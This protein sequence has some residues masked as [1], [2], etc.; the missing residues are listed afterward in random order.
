[1]MDRFILLTILQVVALTFAFELRCPVSGEW[2]LRA[3]TFNCSSSQYVCL[4]HIRYRLE[5]IYKESCDELDY[6]SIGSKL[7]FQPIFNQAQCTYKRYQPF[8]F[9]TDGSSNCVYHKS[10]CNEEGQYVFN[11]G[12][13]NND[14]TCGCNSSKG[15]KFIIKPRNNCFCIPSEEDCSCHKVTC[16]ERDHPCRQ[17]GSVFMNASCLEI[18]TK[19]LPESNKSA[20]SVRGRINVTQYKTEYANKGIS[21]QQYCAYATVTLLIIMIS[22]VPIYGE[23]QVK[24]KSKNNRNDIF[25]VKREA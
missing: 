25:I 12:S 10:F 24:M 5:D 9:S 17:D 20:P 3:K 11:K 18:T 8:L 16:N 21:Y 7:V 13:F 19:G 22:T 4:L 15:Y 2:R 1:M 14:T 23:Y 6:S